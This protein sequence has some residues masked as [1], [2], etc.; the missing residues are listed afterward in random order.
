MANH[1]YTVRYRCNDGHRTPALI[2]E[3]EQGTAY[4]YRGGRLRGW[5]RGRNASG[6]LARVLQRR[7]VCTR[8]PEVP[9][10]TLEGL[11]RL[12]GEVESRE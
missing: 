10:Y 4:L 8:V 11:R 3:D 5:L 6:R 2:V 7:A 12:T 1:H 9:P